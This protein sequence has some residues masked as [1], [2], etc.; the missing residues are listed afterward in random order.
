MF[1]TLKNA[2]KTKDVRNK[3]LLTLGI[4]LLYRVGCWLPLPGLNPTWYS[5]EWN[6]DSGSFLALISAIGGNALRNGAWLALGVSP[7][8]NA[9]IIIQLLTIALP[10]L[11][12]LSKQGEDGRKKIAQITRYLTLVLGAAQCVGIIISWAN[13]G[14]IV[15]AQTFG[16]PVWLMGVIIGFFMLAGTTFTMWLGEKIT[17]IGVGNGISLLIFVGILSTAGQSLQD[18]V[19]AS[20]GRGKYG[21]DPNTAMWE[22]IFFLIMV[23]AIFVLIVFIDGAE[24]KIPIQYAKQIKG[25]KQYGGQSTHIPIKVNATG[26]LPIIFATA[27]VSFPQMLFSMFATSATDTTQGFG[28]FYS[29]WSRNIGTGSWPHS[30][31]VAL[32]IFGFSYFYAQIQFKPEEVSRNLQ[33]YGGL[34]PG[35]RQGRPTTEYLGRISK[36]LTFFG[37][38]FLV[39]IALI[40]TIVFKSTLGAPGSSRE[41]VGLVNAFSATGLLIVVSVALEFDKQLE[42]LLM[43][44]HYKGFLK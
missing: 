38:L 35:I 30:I 24:R 6:V 32:L 3:I 16:G 37:A 29:W 33:Q 21:G 42:S 18:A 12:R 40:P 13:D 26:V 8:I 1:T 20:F 39:F 28:A 5:Q 43:M 15:P 36:R 25:R 23:T 11:E 10:P 41:T 2:F 22:L 7:Y 44:K 19:L 9:S 17:E 4:L 31:I 34:I 27:L 14:N